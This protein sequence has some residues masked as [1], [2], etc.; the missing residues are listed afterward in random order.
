MGV[1]KVRRLGHLSLASLREATAVSSSLIHIFSV[2]PLFGSSRID[3]QTNQLIWIMYT[4]ITFL[5]FDGV[6]VQ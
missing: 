2:S 4:Y 1:T 3:R 6:Y 5:F